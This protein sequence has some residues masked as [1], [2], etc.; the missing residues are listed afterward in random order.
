VEEYGARK[1]VLRVSTLTAH[2]SQQTKQTCHD[3]QPH[4]DMNPIQILV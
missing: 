1:V 4:M 2:F 3:C